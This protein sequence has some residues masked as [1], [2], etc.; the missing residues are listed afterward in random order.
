[1]LAP[2]P[3]EE[4]AMNST[5]TLLSWKNEGRAE[6][7]AE[8]MALGML[9]ARREDLLK[10]LRVKFVNLPAEMKS[11]VFGNN[12]LDQLGRWFDAALAATSLEAYTVLVRRL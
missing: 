1:M 5:A 12:D 4:P 6:G 11:S 3:I 2:T 9:E 8:G 10:I 7:R